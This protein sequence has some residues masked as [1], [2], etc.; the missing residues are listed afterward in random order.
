MLTKEGEEAL[1][2]KPKGLDQVLSPDMA[3]PSF[4]PAPP[5]SPAEDPEVS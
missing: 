3:D 1:V 4:P 5:P 2:R